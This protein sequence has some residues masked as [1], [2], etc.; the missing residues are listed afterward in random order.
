MEIVPTVVLHIENKVN[1]LRQCIKETPIK[2]LSKN[3]ID[4]NTNT[5]K[6]AILSKSFGKIY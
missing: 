5:S 6:N 3:K 1:G 4:D 2:M